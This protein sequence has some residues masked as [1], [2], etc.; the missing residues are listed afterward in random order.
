MKWK[1]TVDIQPYRGESTLCDDC[2][3]TPPNKAR[4]VITGIG[5]TGHLYLCDECKETLEDD[6]DKIEKL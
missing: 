2:Q 3:I 4:W 6:I 5:A 1:I